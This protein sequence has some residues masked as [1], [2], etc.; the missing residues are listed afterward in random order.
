ML[1][2]LL[3]TYTPNSHKIIQEI[4]DDNHGRRIE[5]EERGGKPLLLS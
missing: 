1:P 4:G 3:Q 2:Q 5:K